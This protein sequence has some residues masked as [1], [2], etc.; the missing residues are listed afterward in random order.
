MRFSVRPLADYQSRDARWL[1]F[2]SACFMT[3]I[4]MAF[5]AL[6]FAV[7]LGDVAFYYYSGYILSYA[8]MQGIQSGFVFHPLEF[9]FI[10]AA[11]LAWYRLGVGGSVVLPALFLDAFANLRYYVP[12][13]HRTVLGFG[14]V[15]AAATLIGFLPWPAATVISHDLFNP[16]LV[17]GLANMLVSTIVAVWRGSRY[18]RFFLVGWTPLLL[19]SGFGSAQMYGQFA[20]WTW[21]DSA[22]IAVGA[23]EAI[24]LSFGLID[25]TL[26][27]RMERDQARRLAELDPLTSL[28]NR[29]AWI[30]QVQGLLS[31]SAQSGQA[32]TLIF[33]DLDHFKAL[34]DRYGHAAGDEA[35]LR[36]AET[37][38][39]TLR[40][41]DQLGRYGGDEFVAALPHCTT[42]SARHIADR[43]LSGINGLT[44]PTDD[45]GSTLGASI[46]IATLQRSERIEGLLARAD[47]AMYT[48]KSLGRNRVVI[49]D[50]GMRNHAS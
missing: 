42:D 7:R 28:L 46:G 47:H 9:G 5:I 6:V 33:V 35:L 31:N 50:E 13:A 3:M 22:R 49:A 32:L 21:V 43:I 15:A 4:L 2:A 48:A 14:F 10:N 40:P 36:I 37:L 34:N 25:R 44:I 8:L 11:P 26:V 29:R 41:G 24:V 12:L 18:A 1:T 45:R 23:F 39:G 19:V 20:S 16:I 17:L 27:V 30:A 38:H